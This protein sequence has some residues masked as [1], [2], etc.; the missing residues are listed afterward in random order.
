MSYSL[1]MRVLESLHRK[2]SVNRFQ[3]N[4]ANVLTSYVT[5]EKKRQLMHSVEGAIPSLQ[6]LEAPWRELASLDLSPTGLF[7]GHSRSYA[8]IAQ[9]WDAH[10]TY[11]EVIDPSVCKEQ[12]IYPTKEVSRVHF[13]MLEGYGAFFD[14]CLHQNRRNPHTPSVRH[15][16]T[17]KDVA[18]IFNAPML[19]QDACDFFLTFPRSKVSDLYTALGLHPRTGERRFASEGI[20]ALAIKRACAI[21]SASRYILWSD[22]TLAEIAAK[23]GY[24]DGAHLHH[25]FRRSTG[26]I[27]P[28]AYRRAVRVQ[29]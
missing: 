20:S 9:L 1:P 19:L 18:R 4:V 26:G 28:A 14:H 3:E 29:H 10:S 15:G 2:P 8:E 22:L 6:S 13:R 27:P 12:G 11:G 7:F 5:L 23:C 21:S 16:F 24:T 17:L 25:E